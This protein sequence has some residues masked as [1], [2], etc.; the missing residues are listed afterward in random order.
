MFVKKFQTINC[1][2]NFTVFY[3]YLQSSKFQEYVVTKERKRKKVHLIKIYMTKNERK[4]KAKDF[5]L[6]PMANSMWK[7]GRYSEQKV[8]AF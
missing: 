6:K 1:D 4:K 7:K 8:N 3:L 5:P 2:Y